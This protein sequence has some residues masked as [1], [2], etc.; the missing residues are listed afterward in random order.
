MISDDLVIWTVQ[1]ASSRCSPL[2]SDTPPG[3]SVTRVLRGQLASHS[4]FRSIDLYNLCNCRTVQIA[5]T[6]FRLS[7]GTL[8]PPIFTTVAQVELQT[9]LSRESEDIDNSNLCD[10]RTPEIGKCLSL[11]F[12]GL[13]MSKL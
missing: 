10:C 12:W 11:E 13:G 5:N 4:G 1:K 7:F 8:T 6:Y 3:E 2:C 9:Q